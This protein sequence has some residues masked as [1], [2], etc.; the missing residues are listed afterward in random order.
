[1]GRDRVQNNIGLTASSYMTKYS[2]IVSYMTVQCASDPSKFSLQ[3]K[4]YPIFFYQCMVWHSRKELP[5]FS[6][7]VI[8]IPKFNNLSLCYRRVL[9][10][11]GDTQED[12]EREM[13]CWRERGMG[14]RGAES[15][16]RKKAWS[17]INHSILS[18]AVYKF[19]Y[20]K[21]GPLVL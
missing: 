7:P 5:L 1:M 6:G 14:G 8:T 9:D 13:I 2:R 17:Y 3:E 10:W 21:N 19:L 18:A 16:D 20:I 15:Y 12:W 11:T 4:Y